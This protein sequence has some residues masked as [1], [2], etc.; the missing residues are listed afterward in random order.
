IVFVIFLLLSFHVF[1][2]PSKPIANFMDTPASAFDVFLFRLKENGECYQSYWGNP[3]GQKLA[4]C[5]TGLE[6][7]FDDNILDMKFFVSSRH[8]M[9]QGLSGKTQKEKEGAIKRIL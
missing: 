5:L 9:M 4:L 7:R 3:G 8:E 6:Y 1:S 2:E